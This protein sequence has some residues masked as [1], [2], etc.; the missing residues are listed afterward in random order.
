MDEEGILCK[1]G[2]VNEPLCRC[3]GRVFP[4]L[5]ESP[6]DGRIVPLAHSVTPGSL[7]GGGVQVDTESV[8]HLPPPAVDKFPPDVIKNPGW[9]TK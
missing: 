2:H 8:C 3:R 1:A 6:L 4:K 7:G 5:A 9:G